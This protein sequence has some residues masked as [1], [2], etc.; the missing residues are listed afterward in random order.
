MGKA[1][2]RPQARIPFAFLL[3][4]AIFLSAADLRAQQPAQASAAA[5]GAAP[6]T[7][8]RTASPRDTL[9]SYTALMRQTQDALISYRRDKTAANFA[10]L[11]AVRNQLFD[12]VDLREVPRASR[13]QVAME[14]M[15]SLADIF[16]RIDLPALRDVPDTGTPGVDELPEFWRIPRTPIRIVRIDDGPREGEFLFAARTARIAPRFAARIE[17]KPLRVVGGIE[18]WR[19]LQVQLTGPLIPRAFEDA[20]PDVLKVPWLGTP[21]WK[22]LVALAL[23]ALAVAA[24]YAFHRRIAAHDDPSQ[25][26]ALGRRLL[27]P[28]A[29]CAAV[30]ALHWFVQSQLKLFGDA[31]AFWDALTVVVF[32][33]VAVWVTWLLVLGLFEAII[34]SPAIPEESLDANL[35]RLLARVIGLVAGVFIAAYGAQEI[36]LPLF[37]VLAGLG[38][39]GLAVALALRPTIE[40]LIGGVILYLDKPIR[41]GDF[42]SYGDR[43]GTVEAIGVRTTQIRALDRTLVSIPNAQ[44]ADNEIINWAQCDKMLINPTIGVRYET[45]PDQMRFVLVSLREMLIAHPK[46]ETETAR[47]RMSEF[48]DFSKNI[49]IRIFALT[50][51]WNEFHAIREDVLLRIDD[52]VTRA[53]IGFAFPSRTLYLGRDARPDEARGAV[54]EREVAD[55]RQRGQ[56]P[57]PTSP[58]ERVAAID[59]TLD[60]PPRGSA[61]AQT[62]PEAIE[63]AAEP[64]AAP[65]AD[66]A[67]DPAKRERPR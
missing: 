1:P 19:E 59:G 4:V 31:S 64:L 32:Y 17:D 42:C 12:L 26:K 60:Y 2:L 33:A 47:V 65:E 53:G 30:Y 9:R 61:S 41:V 25:L 67:D 54:S 37:S 29:I 50:N 16:A 22:I 51:D 35:L 62:S 3:A 18:S 48:A 56:L 8:A 5:A 15:A 14:T 24:L 28:I 40:N 11:T 45:T 34:L 21:A 6:L 52:I 57:F 58:S 39:G 10:A 63:A 44:F 38:V 27:T 55:W 7:F 43:M 13:E 49:T 36:G 23:L 46:I 66:E 20:I